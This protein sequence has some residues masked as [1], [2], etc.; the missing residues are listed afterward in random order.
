MLLRL[1]N[2]EGLRVK[3]VLAALIQYA[4]RV[5]SSW[6]EQ[7]ADLKQKIGTGHWQEDVWHVSG[8]PRFTLLLD[9]ANMEQEWIGDGDHWQSIMDASEV[10]PSSLSYERISAIPM[11][12]SFCG[13]T[14]RLPYLIADGFREERQIEW[15]PRELIEPAP[16]SIRFPVNW[17]K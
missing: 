15:V 6:L 7:V 10:E 1:R 9:S 3:E 13:H 8:I 17:D 12:R 16:S 14:T 2:D 4:P 5:L 11:P